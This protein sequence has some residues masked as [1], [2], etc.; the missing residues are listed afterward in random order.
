[1]VAKNKSISQLANF[2]KEYPQKLTNVNV[3]RKIPFEKLPLLS[4]TMRQSKKA[5]G[6]NGRIVVRYS[7]TENKL[8]IL[9]EAKS[10]SLVSLWTSKI[11]AAVEKELCQ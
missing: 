1:M 7:G 4:E 3:S 2:M 10:A 5:L 8:R 9:V 6:E 11:K